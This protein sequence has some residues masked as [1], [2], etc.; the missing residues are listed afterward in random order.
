MAK[1]PA[2]SNKRKRN[3]SSPK[4]SSSTQQQPPIRIPKQ[5]TLKHPLAN[6]KLPRE[7]QNQL[8]KTYIFPLTQKLSN[9]CMSTQTALK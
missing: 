5:L 9:T 1:K 3:K 2:A 4:S 6:I 7:L 8:Y